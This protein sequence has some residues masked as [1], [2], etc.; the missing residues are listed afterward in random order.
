[1]RIYSEVSSISWGERVELPPVLGLRSRVVEGGERGNE[2]GRDLA[3]RSISARIV[4]HEWHVI[5][6]VRPFMRSNGCGC[7]RWNMEYVT[8]QVDNTSSLL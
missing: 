4:R 2:P 3:D 5:N 1:M 7:V 8:T 6:G